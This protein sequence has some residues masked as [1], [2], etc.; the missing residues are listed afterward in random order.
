MEHLLIT[1][2][3]QAVRIALLSAHTVPSTFIF[4]RRKL[5]LREMTSVF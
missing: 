2:S 1:Y 5:K 4:Q 3:P